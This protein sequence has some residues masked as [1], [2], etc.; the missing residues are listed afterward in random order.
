MRRSDEAQRL[1]GEWRERPDRAEVA[2]VVLSH[3]TRV[4]YGLLPCDVI[5]VCQRTEHALG[6]VQRRRAE[7]VAPIRDWNPAFAFVHVFH[8][9]TEKI[10]RLPTYQELRHLCQ[11]D[12][13]AIAMLGEPSVDKWRDVER[14]GFDRAE[15]K[16]AIRWRVGN[17]YY[18][19][20]REIYVLSFCRSRGVDLCYHPLADA[21]LRVDFWVGDVI[22]SLYIDNPAYRQGTAGRK[23]PPQSIL[24]DARPA[25][26]YLSAALPARNS[27]GDVHLPKNSE[28]EEL[29]SQLNEPDR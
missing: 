20:L 4:V 13:G 24:S 21:L 3:V 29:I 22:L 7:G 14:E 10:G 17:A 6:D 18:S 15:V 19:F 5:G 27:F 11:E 28:L 2:P 23:E 26:R 8:Y 1:L 16:D 9:L 25:F 12:Q